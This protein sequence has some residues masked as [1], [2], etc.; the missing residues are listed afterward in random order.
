MHNNNIFNKLNNILEENS[1]LSDQLEFALDFL[2]QCLSYLNHFYNI[3]N[4]DNI[5]IPIHTFTKNQF[6]DFLKDLELN[7]F[8]LLDKENKLND[9]LNPNPILDPNNKNYNGSKNLELTLTMKDNLIN[10]LIDENNKLSKELKN[11]KDVNNKNN[12]KKNMF[13][14]DNLRIINA[15]TIKLESQCPNLTIENIDNLSIEEHTKDIAGQL[16]TELSSHR[17]RGKFKKIDPNNLYNKYYDGKIEK[18]AKNHWAS[19]TY[20]SKL[21]K[22]GKRTKVIEAKVEEKIELAPKQIIPPIKK[23]YAHLLNKNLKEIAEKFVDSK[24]KHFKVKKFD[25]ENN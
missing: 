23:T 5:I 16:G 11:L 6:K 10:N 14:T 2:D 7:L 21:K 8:D 18:F 3:I 17:Y 22:D 19:D 12:N 13:N 20:V 4:K 9:I 25:F 1:Q 24:E 15:T